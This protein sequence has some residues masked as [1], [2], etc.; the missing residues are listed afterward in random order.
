MKCQKSSVGYDKEVR[1][2]LAD[3]FVA[4]SH[5]FISDLQN[6][7]GDLEKTL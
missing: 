3:R 2:F 6:I 1:R 7:K 4:Q 5:F